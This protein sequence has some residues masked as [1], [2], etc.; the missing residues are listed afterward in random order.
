MRDINKIKYLKKA[1][2]KHR[3]KAL[4]R[5]T[6]ERPR[7]A[8]KRSLR[9]IF[10]Q[11]IDDITGKTLIACSDLD[12]DLSGRSFDSKVKA[13]KAVGEMIA[14][15]CLKKGIKSVVFDRASSK[16]HGRVK[17]LAEAARKQGLDF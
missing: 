12:K 7:M 14:E 6:S 16:Y 5:S 11:V 17:A 10:V 8:V 2:R 15:R 9:H 4:I 1:R 13:A 3:V